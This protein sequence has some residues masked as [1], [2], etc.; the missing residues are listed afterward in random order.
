MKTVVT[1]IC[2]ALLLNIAANARKSTNL[3]Q[4]NTSTMHFVANENELIGYW[5]YTVDNAP[6]EYSRGVMV[7]DKSDGRYSVVVQLN[8][9]SIQGEDVQVKDNEISF[10]VIVEGTT[11]T[12]TLTADKDTLSGQ[13]V[14][15]EGT[16]TIKGVRAVMPE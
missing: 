15:S 13:S 16:M 11:V 3:M 10:K 12:V 5:N 2:A 7:I 6:Y 9:G 8:Q 4:Y 14:S 1:F